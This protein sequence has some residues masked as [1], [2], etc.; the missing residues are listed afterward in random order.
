MEIPG[1]GGDIAIPLK[2]EPS[3]PAASL[4]ITIQ[5]RDGTNTTSVPFSLVSRSTN[6]GVPGGYT[7]LLIES[8]DAIWLTVHPRPPEP[9]PTPPE[10]T[11]A[12]K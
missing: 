6:N 5:I 9:A 11:V 3:A 4:P 10:E 12:G 1:K 8:T 2:V 7:S